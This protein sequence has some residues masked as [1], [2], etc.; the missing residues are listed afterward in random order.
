MPG[1]SISPSTSFTRPTGWPNSAGG[2][3]SCTTTTWPDLGR[4]GRALGDQDVLAVALVFGRDEP[5]AA[6]VQ[7]PAD[8]RLL[9]ALDDL[10]HAALGAA[11]AVLAHD[12][13]L[14]AVLVQHRAHLV[15]G[16]IDVGFAVVALH[17]TVAVAMSLDRAFNFIQQAAGMA[18]NF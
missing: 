10:D 12:A 1:S 15:G 9:G 13:R 8:D 6:F 16:Q 17:E 18:Y 14:D 3:V 11:A 4:A 2:S 5:D 7:Q